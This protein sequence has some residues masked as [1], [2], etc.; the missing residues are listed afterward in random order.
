VRVLGQL[1]DEDLRAVYRAAT[2]FAFPSLAEGFGLPVL[3]AM[4][5]GTP[6]VT[7]AGTATADAAGDAAVLVDPADPSALAR[8][9]EA[10]AGDDARRRSLAAAGRDRAAGHTWQATAEGY[11]DA[12]ARAVERGP[13]RGGRGR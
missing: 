12:I 10:V 2:V 7:S 9:I 1:S 3:E 8:A 6:V 13:R 11:R 4:A 5:Q